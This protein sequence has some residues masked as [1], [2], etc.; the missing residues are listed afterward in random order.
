MS[1]IVILTGALIAIVNMVV[2]TAN[3]AIDRRMRD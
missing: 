2:D 1:A 3:A